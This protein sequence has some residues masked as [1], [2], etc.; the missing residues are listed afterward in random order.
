MKNAYKSLYIASAIIFLIV[1]L[2]GSVTKP[3]FNGFSE[4]SLNTIGIKKSSVDS[5]DNSI[6]EM[7]YKVN[8]V[9]LKIEKLKNLF[10]DEKID[11]EK[12]NKVK[13]GIIFRNVYTPVVEVLNTTYRIVFF[14][15]SVV[16][17]FSAVILHLIFRNTDLKRRIAVLEE[18]VNQ[19]VV[20]N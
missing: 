7:L 16:V 10:S 1:I 17:L 3:V 6:D 8:R 2:G 5:V 4:S 9:N 19:L 18:K 13:N 12:Y 11:E 14:I 15:I 20:N